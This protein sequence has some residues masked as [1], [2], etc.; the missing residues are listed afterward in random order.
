MGRRWQGEVIVSVGQRE[1]AC[2]HATSRAYH[3]DDTL[4]DMR[5]QPS[6]LSSRGP[7]LQIGPRS[8]VEMGQAEGSPRCVIQG[9]GAYV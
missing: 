1:H 6:S 9:A 4:T 3:D 2:K 5:S 7:W 8:K